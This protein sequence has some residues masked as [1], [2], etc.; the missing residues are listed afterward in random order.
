MKASSILSSVAMKEKFKGLLYSEKKVVAA[1]VPLGTASASW[2]EQLCCG[3]VR[4]C[5]L[6]WPAL[7]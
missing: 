6:G 4:F 7:P 2:D 3:Y 1:V 5:A